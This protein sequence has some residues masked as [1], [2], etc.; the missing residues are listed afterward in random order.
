[1]PSAL[2]TESLT[3]LFILIYLIKKLLLSPPMYINFSLFFPPPAFILLISLLPVVSRLWR[4]GVIPLLLSLSSLLPFSHSSLSRAGNIPVPSGLW[5]DWEVWD[6]ILNHPY[7]PLCS[8]CSVVLFLWLIYAKS[9]YTYALHSSKYLE[10]FKRTCLWDL[11]SCES[12]ILCFTQRTERGFRRS[13]MTCY[14]CRKSK[15]QCRVQRC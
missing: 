3:W 10:N 11:H 8:L 5:C 7:P 4:V 13:P 9:S 12:H 15:Q 2:P 14:V 6:G 1:M